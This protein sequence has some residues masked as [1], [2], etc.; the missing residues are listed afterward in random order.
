M[1]PRSF[2]C[3]IAVVVIALSVSGYLSISSSFQNS[4]ARECTR[5]I[6]EHQLLKFTLQTSILNVAE[7]G[8]MTGQAL[9][10][11]AQQT[12]KIAPKR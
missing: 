3:T 4:V 12:A 6:E 11:I 5:G 7:N 9:H 2:L 8:V 1:P 10:T